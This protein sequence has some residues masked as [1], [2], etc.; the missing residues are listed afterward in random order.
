MTI[1]HV[2]IIQRARQ[3]RGFAAGAAASENRTL[4]GAGMTDRDVTPAA[5]RDIGAAGRKAWH[6]CE[7]CCALAGLDRWAIELGEGGPLVAALELAG[8]RDAR[9]RW[10]HQPAAAFTVT[11]A[12]AARTCI[13]EFF[14]PEQQAEG[15]Q[16]VNLASRT[17]PPADRVRYEEP[18]GRRGRSGGIP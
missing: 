17:T 11:T 1:A 7:R 9:V 2:R 8:G 18:R 12:D 14:T 10:T 13:A 3:G 16:P 6:L 15:L 4:C 5:A